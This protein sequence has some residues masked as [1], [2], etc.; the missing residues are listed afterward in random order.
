MPFTGKCLMDIPENQIE[1]AED[2][3]T[4]VGIISPSEAPLL[5]H[6]G[7]PGRVAMSGLH[8]WFDDDLLP[9]FDTIKQTTFT[10]NAT[11]A[12]VLTT[13]KP[14]R[15]R[16]GDLLRP[17]GSS[18]VMLV[19]DITDGVVRVS[20]RYGASKGS[21]LS[22]GQRLLIIGNPSIEGCAG[23]SQSRFINRVA[24][25]NYAQVFSANV[26]A[27]EQLAKDRG[28]SIS[29]EMDYQK[30]TRLRQLLRDLES[31]V[32]NGVSA[33]TQYLGTVLR[34]AM[35]GIIP[36]LTTNVMT[37]GAGGIPRGD[38]GGTELS[39][40]M[41]NAAA[42]QI[43]DGRSVLVNTIVVGGTM[44]RRINAFRS[45]LA[46]VDMSGTRYRDAINVYES[47]FGP[48]KIVLSRWVPMDAVLLLDST[49][50][51][52]LPLLGRSF[53]YKNLPCINGQHNG[54]VVGEYT[55]EVRNEAAHGVI[56]GLT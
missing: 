31:C 54:L 1:N 30:H 4:L 21:A 13:I 29:D 19:L 12:T 25:S 35:S 43:W 3:A 27:S 6:L 15:L 34:H 32:I 9:N 11:D 17:N 37:P 56:R 26:S 39:E 14:S 20:R 5:D 36:Q 45:S 46:D 55:L 16:V 24:K 47:D 52:V 40:A 38:G 41:L 2:L 42:K 33:S 22:S 48:C 53:A 50:L 8:S 44:K 18:E 23:E 28:I 7:D 51:S 49:R 10:P